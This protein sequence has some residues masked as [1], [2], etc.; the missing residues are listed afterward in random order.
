M[1]LAWMDPM[2][3]LYVLK[4]SV[5]CLRGYVLNNIALIPAFPVMLKLYVSRFPS[6]NQCLINVY[7]FRRNNYVGISICLVIY[8]YCLAD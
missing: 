6:D 7:C 1:S 4:Y 3:A 2:L 8:N 5:L